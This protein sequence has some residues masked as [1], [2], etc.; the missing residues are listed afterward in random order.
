MCLVCRY[1]HVSAGAWGGQKRLWAFSGAR[2]TD[3][4]NSFNLVAGNQS[5]G[6][7]IGSRISQHLQISISW[8]ALFW[9]DQLNGK[10]QGPAQHGAYRHMGQFHRYWVLNSCPCVYR[11]GKN[12]T[13]WLILPSPS[14][15]ITRHI[16]QKWRG[17]RSRWNVKGE[18]IGKD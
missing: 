18:L 10:H 16:L 13:H 9:L 15:F 1:V 2:L 4:S 6:F 3:S 14:R 7:W 17:G 8:S 5:L 11:H 12:F